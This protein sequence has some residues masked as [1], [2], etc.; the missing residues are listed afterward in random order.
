MK[1]N[2]LKNGHLKFVLKNG[3]LHIFSA[4]LI[5]KIIQFCSGVILIRFF[6]KEE[7]GQYSYA[8]NILSLFLLVEGIGVCSGLLQYASENISSE[9]KLGYVKIAF[10]YGALFDIILGFIIFIFTLFFSLP[11][12]GSSI[13]L[14][15]MF[16]I[17]LFS[18][19]FN[20][21]ET[22]LRS[23]LKNFQYSALSVMNTSL[24]LVCSIIGAILYNILGVII[25]RYIAYLI[26]DIIALIMIRK[27]L[28]LIKTVPLPIKE[29]RNVFIKYSITSML[30]NSI[31]GLLYLIDTFLVGLIIRDSSTVAAYK[32][33]TVIPFA[34][35]FIPSSVMIFVYPYFARINTNKS[36]F[37]QYYFTLIKYMG[38][39]NILISLLF[40]IC[41]PW[42][43]NIVFGNNYSDIIIPF[44]ILA[45]GFFFVGTFRIPSG[46]L[47]AAAEKIK[48]NFY[49]S[50]ISGVTN[51]VLDI[52]F[53]LWWGATGA[54][55]STVCIFILDGSI[56]TLFLYNYLRK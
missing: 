23:T 11:I 53:I 45:L 3:F 34:L 28:C 9:K 15:W 31:S 12:D 41:A 14:R 26:T 35:N 4:N 39:L 5:N 27:E 6:S 49:L 20:I 36:K 56:S 54:A 30:C 7:Y 13:I 17:P 24:V 50:I 40:F 19:I 29:E 46:N 51:I 16:L 55:I 42:I 2:F 52:L 37:K 43:I 25:G 22:Y 8:G 33:S 21:I 32:T 47:L 18:F 10:S 44:R 48:V 38:C 1:N